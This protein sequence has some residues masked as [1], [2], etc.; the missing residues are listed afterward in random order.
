MI[1]PIQLI[2]NS[3][4][5]AGTGINA[6]LWQSEVT[7]SI[8]AGY[9]ENGVALT[10]IW[11]TCLLPDNE[12]MSE[13]AMVETAIGLQL[14]PGSAVNVVATDEVGNVLDQVQLSGP[15]GLPVLWAVAHTDAGAA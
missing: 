6:K 4:V 10:W 3:F 11:Q 5:G 7:P 13:N 12:Q 15:P 14:P 1:A 2:T 9:T 8:N